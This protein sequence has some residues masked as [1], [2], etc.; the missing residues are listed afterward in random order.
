MEVEVIYEDESIIV[1]YKPSG[2]ATQTMKVTEQDMVSYLSNYRAAKGEDTFVGVITRLDQP[3]EGV[4]VFGKTKKATAVLS[5][6]LQAHSI[7][8]KYYAIITRGALPEDGTLVDYLV[9]DSKAA[10][11][12]VVSEDDPR[13]KRA[14]LHYRTVDQVDDRN[15]LDVELVTGRFH[16]I[17]CQLASRTAPILGDVKYG[18]QRTGRPLCLASYE[19]SF[20]HPDTG[21]DMTFTITPRGEDFQDFDFAR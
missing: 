13:A 12:K 5:K 20:K 8:K 2:I 6:E 17:R 14:E 15:L 10:R 11:A 16:Q 18:G 19:I 9:K 21:E 7:A 1:C 3:V 4:L